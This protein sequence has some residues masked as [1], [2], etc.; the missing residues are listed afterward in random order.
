MAS[1]AWNA[2]AEKPAV[3]EGSS[4]RFALQHLLTAVGLRHDGGNNSNHDY[5]GSSAEVQS[6]QR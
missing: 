2:G 6:Y 5:V 1:V 3:Y 4:E